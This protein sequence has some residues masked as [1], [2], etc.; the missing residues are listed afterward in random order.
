MRALA[1]TTALSLLAFSKPLHAFQRDP[2]LSGIQPTDMDSRNE[3]LIKSLR[4]AAPKPFLPITQW[5]ENFGQALLGCMIKEHG[6]G[7]SE[8]DFSATK[9]EILKLSEFYTKPTYPA[10]YFAPIH[11]DP[12]GYLTPQSVFKTEPAMMYLAKMGLNLPELQSATPDQCRQFLCNQ[13]IKKTLNYAQ[14]HKQ[15]IE[16]VVDIG[17]G[18]GRTAFSWAKQLP[19]AHVMAVDPS[20]YVAGYVKHDQLM[21]P[22]KYQDLSFTNEFGEN[23]NLADDSVDICSI[24]FVA[25]E[26]PMTITYRMLDHLHHAIKPGG[27]ITIMD[28]DTTGP[29]GQFMKNTPD[30]LRDTIADMAYEPFIRDYYEQFHQIDDFLQ[31]RGFTIHHETIGRYKIT[32]ACKQRG[33]L[34]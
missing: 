6:L 19:K 8:A 32:I 31:Q 33:L 29:A 2:Y 30:F 23:L 15:D 3:F 27:V 25:H 34:L 22:E 28:D 26:L 18:S 10:Y 14:I 16:T 1:T 12:Q 20:P 24:A 4:D 13:F 7:F 17:S 11:G 5:S 9:D 21:F